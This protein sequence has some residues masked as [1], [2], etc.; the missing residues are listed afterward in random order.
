MT[1]TWTGCDARHDVRGFHMTGMSYQPPHLTIGAPRRRL[2]TGADRCYV[3]LAVMGDGATLRSRGPMGRGWPQM[4]ARVIGAAHDLSWCDARSAGA[5]TYDVRR[6]QLRVAV[7][8]RPH[9]VCLA[10][11]LAD[12]RDPQW[13]FAATRAHLLHC[14]RVLSR[15][16]AVLLTTRPGAGR[17]GQAGSWRSASRRL[18]IR[19]LDG[20]Y[21]E[22]HERFGT[23]H[24]DP[25]DTGGARPSAA[26]LTGR[27][28]HELTRH[29]LELPVV[30]LARTS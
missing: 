20:L 23:I 11:G 21:D 14:A 1:L 16:G 29:G 4:L 25:G 9:L 8:Q 7:A 22:L 24:L 3:R 5:T 2:E 27:F 26:E 12:V 6:V 15:R 30:S 13:D 10:A 28:V 17:R 19:Q 18:R